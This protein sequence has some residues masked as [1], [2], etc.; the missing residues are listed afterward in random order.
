MVAAPH[1]AYMMPLL[2]GIGCVRRAQ[3][4]YQSIVQKCP[5]QWGIRTHIQYMASLAHA[6][7]PSKL[8]LDRFSRFY[9]TDWCFQH[10]DRPRNM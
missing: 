7:Q 10:T 1:R 8:H 6:Y 5:F 9:I 2:R 3:R 4:L